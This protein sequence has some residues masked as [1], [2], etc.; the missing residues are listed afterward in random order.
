[1]YFLALSA[2]E[3]PEGHIGASSDISEAKKRGV[4]IG[5]YT[6][7][8]NPYMLNDSLQLTIKQAWVEQHWG[9]GANNSTIASAGYQLCINTTEADET[10]I[11]TADAHFGISADLYLRE[12]SNASYLGDTDTFPGDSIA[13]LV[14]KGNH[15]MDDSTQKK[16]IIGK[17]ILIKK[18]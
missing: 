16:V 15:F 10:A 18:Q 9:Y 7:S 3:T 12:R 2:C 13:Y 14:Q 1:M 6:V 17:L 5:E 4:F 8:P 11:E